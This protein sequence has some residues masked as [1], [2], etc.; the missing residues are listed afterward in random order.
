MVADRVKISDSFGSTCIPGMGLASTSCNSRCSSLT[1]RSFNRGAAPELLTPHSGVVIA[2]GP[3]ERQSQ[4]EYNVIHSFG[5]L[6]LLLAPEQACRKHLQ[7]LGQAGILLGKGVDEA[8]DPVHHGALVLFKTRSQ[9]QVGVNF[10][11]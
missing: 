3:R 9:L 4:E 11:D 10:L 6:M 7:H 2:G 5:I 8:R 1:P